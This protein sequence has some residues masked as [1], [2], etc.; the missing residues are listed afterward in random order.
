[1]LTRVVAEKFIGYGEIWW[2]HNAAFHYDHADTLTRITHRTLILT[3]PD[4]IIYDAALRARDLRPDF[5]F[6]E[7]PGGGVDAVDAYPEEWARLVGDFLA[8]A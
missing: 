2:G 7:L 5:A 8:G 4:D 6:A 1:V 3:N